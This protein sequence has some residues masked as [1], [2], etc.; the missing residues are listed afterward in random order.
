MSGLDAR[1]LHELVVRPALAALPAELATPAAE[2]LILGTAAVES[3]FTWLR[4]LPHGPALGLWQMEP[5]TFR[6]IRDRVLQGRP[7]IARA[8]SQTAVALRPEPDELCWNLRLAALCCRIRYLM[9]PRPLPPAGDVFALATEW[10][11]TYNTHMGAGKPADFE[12]AW[13]NLIAP[14]KIDWRQA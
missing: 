2:Q 9:S 5:L 1:Q 7:L 4:Q 8:F 11:T 13:A 6:D 3:N 10:K 12:R 14:A